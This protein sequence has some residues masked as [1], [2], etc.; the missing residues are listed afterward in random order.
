MTDD[1]Q[2]TVTEHLEEL[3]TR[4][5]RSTAALAVGFVVGWIFRRDILY[6]LKKPL[7]D[8]LP[9]EMRHT[10]LLRVIDKFFI[11]LKVA[12]IG[13]VFLAAPYVLFQLWRF[14][15]PG[16]Y[17]HERL[18]ALPVLVAGTLL[19]AA[20]VAFC[21]LVVL[22]FGFDFFVAY[23]LSPD[24][25]T[26]GG[27]PSSAADQLQI[28]LREHIGFTAAFLFVF[29]IAFETPL[30]M[31]ALGWVGVVPPQWFARQRRFAIVFIFIIAAILTPPDP[32]SQISMA[33][34][35]LLLYELGIWSTN[36]LL[37]F[38]RK[39]ISTSSE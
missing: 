13:A 7:L 27:G 4:L 34:P 32:W 39:S 28:A 21:Y 30:A 38:R 2:L 19:F 17:K 3:R 9:E 5:I 35:L 22:P 33:I 20:G 14:V 36:L 26:L 15:S 10:I 16:L 18:V 1:A 24:A 31:F 23:S 8:A 6:L 11:D 12:T 37:R 25:L 29:G